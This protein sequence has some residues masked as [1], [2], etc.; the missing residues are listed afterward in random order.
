[1]DIIIVGIVTAINLMVLWKKFTLGRYLD[2]ALDITAISI[3]AP[4]FGGTQ[5]GMYVAMIASLIITITLYFKP[6]RLPEW[7]TS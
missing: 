2:L 1:M 3:L 4:H 5:G 7:V 6:P